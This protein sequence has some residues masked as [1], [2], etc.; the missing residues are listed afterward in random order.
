MDMQAIVDATPGPAFDVIFSSFAVHHLKPDQKPVFLAG[1]H[2]ILNPGGMF[3]LVDHM[4]P[5]GMSR[6]AYLRDYM[7][8]MRTRWN[9]I[10]AALIE[11]ACD[12]WASALASLGVG[13]GSRVLIIAQNTLPH[14][15]SYCAVPVL[16]RSLCR[17]ISD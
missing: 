14:L 10:P 15:A 9:P 12:R 7:H 2:R 17:S 11:E 6:D 3:L 4:Y 13:P 8:M 1:L 16:V 5:E